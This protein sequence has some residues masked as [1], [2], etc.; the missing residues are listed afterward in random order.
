MIDT[1][2]WQILLVALAGW[3]NRHQLEMI[4]YLREENRAYCPNDRPSRDHAARS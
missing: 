3:A 1:V 2:R 4:A